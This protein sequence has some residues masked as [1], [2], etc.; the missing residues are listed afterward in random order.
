[1]MKAFKTLSILLVLVLAISTSAQTNIQKEDPYIEVIGKAKTEIA[2]DEIYITINI[3]ERIEGKEEIT[4]KEQEIKLKKALNDMN[5]PAE[6]LS[7]SHANSNYIDIKWSKKDVITKTTYILKVT[8]ALEVGQ[9]FEKL[10]KLKIVDANISKVSH[11]KIEDLQKEVRIMAI[12]AAKNKAD[13]LLSAI[14]EQTGK[15]QII[16]EEIQHPYNSNSHG[17]ISNTTANYVEA[18]KMKGEGSFMQFEKIIL[19]SSIYI[20]FNIK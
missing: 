7:L 19:T 12:K 16:R 10:D 5:I 9:V 2:P 6:N 1:M 4:I 8:D 17:A 11:S 18:H 15:P 20:K 14:G 13:Y 3:Q